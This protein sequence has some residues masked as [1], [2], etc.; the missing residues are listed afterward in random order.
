M[1]TYHVETTHVPIQLHIVAAN[2]HVIVRVDSVR[3][4]EE[5]ENTGVLVH[6]FHHVEY[7]HYD[8]MTS[9]CLATTKN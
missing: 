6:L 4:H 7:T 5:P 1:V 2:L 8:V 9:R 3:T